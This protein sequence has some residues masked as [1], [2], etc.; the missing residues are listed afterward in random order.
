MTIQYYCLFW[1]L[2][3]CFFFRDGHR[4][5]WPGN[6][7][8]FCCGFRAGEN[9]GQHARTRGQ[10]EINGVSNLS[11]T[12]WAHYQW[13]CLDACWADSPELIRHPW[14]GMNV[15]Q[16]YYI[17]IISFQANRLA[18]TFLLGGLSVKCHILYW[19]SH[20]LICHIRIS[21]GREIAYWS[22]IKLAIIHTC[23]LCGLWEKSSAPGTHFSLHCKST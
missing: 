20:Y 1:T 11:L 21:T 16:L 5:A 18:L 7:G 19:S 3:C 22:N 4:S 9:G 14:F 12:F 17:M 10:E 8:R 15:L 6:H 13:W 2:F 23:G